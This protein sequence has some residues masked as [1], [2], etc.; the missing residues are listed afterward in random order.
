MKR[1]QTGPEREREMSH[2]IEGELSTIQRNDVS[3]RMHRS[4]DRVLNT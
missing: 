2:S 4:I 1:R 3:T